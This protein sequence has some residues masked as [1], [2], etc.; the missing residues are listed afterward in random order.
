MA[1][2]QLSTSR[3]GAAAE[4]NRR[5]LGIAREVAATLGADFFRCVTTRLGSALR[6][7]FVYLA[8]LAGPLNGRIRTLAVCRD[9]EPAENFDQD[10]SGAVAAQVLSD[11][12]FACG[13]DAVSL[14]PL[15]TLLAGLEAEAYV[16]SRLSDSSG[17]PIGL[18]ALVFRRR[19]GDVALVKSVLEA[20]VERTAAELERKRADDVLRETEQ[21]YRAF[22]ASNPDAMWRIEFEQ[23]IP[24][25]LDEQEQIDRIYRF[26]YLAECNDAMCQLVRAGSVEELEGAR[27]EDLAPRSDTR[28]FE[29]LRNAVRSG[30]RT[31]TVETSPV[32]SSG[33]R[34]YRLRSQFGIVENGELRRLWITTRDITDLRRAE[35]SLAASERRFR[36]VLETIQLPA[37]M[38]DGQGLITFANDCL[39]RL[40]GRS[41]EQWS[42]TNWVEQIVPEEERH[43]WRT[44]LLAKM[45]APETFSSHFE[46]RILAAQGAPR[47]IVWST[48]ALRDQD[49]WRAGLAAIGQDVTD[50]RLLEAE[51]HQ[52]EKLESIG[53]LAGGVAHDFNNLLTV[54]QGHAGQLSHSAGM[55]D[56][57]HSS[58]ESIE[59]A[60]SKCAD[61]T[62]QLLTIG[63]KNQFHPARIRLNDLIVSDENVIRT[64]T[65]EGI[66]LVMEMDPSLGL[67]YADPSQIGRVLTNLVKNAREAM[68]QGGKLVIATSNVS[69]PEKSREF[70]AGAKPGR[71]VRLS[72]VDNGTGLTGETK[73]HL[74]EPF[75]TTKEPGKGTG[76]GLSTVYGI[77]TQSGG[78]VFVRSEPGHGAKFEILL[79]AIEV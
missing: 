58:V 54:I 41:R 38:L 14:F 3:T 21:R 39:L 35:L 48:T 76:L 61:L 12:A 69:I 73:T 62:R 26:G 63:R 79:P 47:T 45:A 57:D 18:L 15:D 34:L 33:H 50:Q 23:P 75:F 52:A 4:R 70:P 30:F 28:V 53:R 20:F 43:A 67:V 36:E 40:A 8:E 71:Y 44:A 37:L 17:Q 27:F 32:D 11:G 60:A 13:K 68:P 2:R 78:Y 7:D 29:E 9:A 72:V 1:R 51:L 64:L 31:M 42:G 46:G 16:G 6:A 10:L 19:L 22:I 74:F 55:S 5:V 49:G 66:E 77:I 59:S 24:V 56:R 25:N 65:G